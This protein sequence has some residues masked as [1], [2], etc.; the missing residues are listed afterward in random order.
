MAIDEK[1][2]TAL[3]RKVDNARSERDRAE[4][5]L[6][7]AMQR[8]EDEFGCKSLPAAK[9]KLA[10]LEREATD[11]EAAYE[12]AVAAFKEEWDGRAELD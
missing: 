1:T 10:T 7:A 5:Q 2:F 4:G 8:L 6:D 3:K 12:E 11:A 9:K